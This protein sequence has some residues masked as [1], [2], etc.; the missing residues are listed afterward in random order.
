MQ[1]GTIGDMKAIKAAVL[2]MGV[3]IF[4]GMIALVY[5]VMQRIED[6]QTTATQD[7]AVGTVVAAPLP[8]GWV[9]RHLAVGDGRIVVEATDGSGAAALFLFDLDS[10]AALGRIDLTGN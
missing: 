1:K 3:L 4:I 10:G 9:T 7:G 8:Q 2:I 6:G 5:G